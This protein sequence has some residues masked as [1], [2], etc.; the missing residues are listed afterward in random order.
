MS[1]QKI[2]FLILIVFIF[3]PCLPAGR[4]FGVSEAK[5]SG[6]VFGWAWSSNIGWIS[7]NKDGLGDI[8][9]GGGDFDYGVSIGTDGNL[10]GYAWSSN[11]GWIKFDPDGPYPANPSHSACVNLPGKTT[12][13]GAGDYTVTGWAR[14]CSVFNSTCSQTTNQVCNVNSDCPTE[15][16]CMTRCSGE[17]NTDRGNWDGWIELHNISIDTSAT[18][19]E[20]HYWVWGGSDDS[21]DT[22]NSEAVIGWGIFNC[23]DTGNCTISNFKAA[24]TFSALGCND[25]QQC[26]P[27]GTLGPCTVE[28]ETVDC[29]NQPPQI[30]QV[31]SVVPNQ[32]LNT[33]QQP[34]APPLTTATFNTDYCV[35][36]INFGWAYFDNNIPSSPETKY[37][38]QVATDS[39]FSSSSI[40]IDIINCGTSFS[41]TQSAY[42]TISPK[43]SKNDDYCPGAF[44]T[45]SDLSYKQTYWWRVIVYNDKGKD[46]G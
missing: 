43:S 26:V 6:N 14:T 23:I 27:G 7:F 36:A 28:N 44:S 35:P 33:P 34:P 42:V 45:F 40:V 13:D 1:R 16:T 38:F 30:D 18:P 10:T 8:S 25:S 21:S 24:T 32:P 37:E 29:N 41:N 2:L 3:S 39:N 4:F 15:E 11:I 5:A 12:C 20:F 22:T 19:A 31:D 46:S 17:L 9:G